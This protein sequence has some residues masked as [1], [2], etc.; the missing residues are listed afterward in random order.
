V[1][2]SPFYDLHFQRYAIYW[3]T[4]DE[5]G[6]E[7][8]REMLAAAEKQEREL[9]ART[10]DFVRLGE[11]QPEIDHD[12]LSERSSSNIGPEGRRWR[13]GQDGGWFSYRMKVPADGTKAAVQLE[14]WGHDNGPVFDL[15]VDGKVIASPQAA[16]KGSEGYYGVEYAIPD[17]LLKS[18][19]TITVRMQARQGEATGLI[20]G[21]R[22]VSTK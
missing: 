1:I 10:V 11:Q 12:M 13:A 7:K 21:L 20:Y 8:R 14:F 6:W 9:D 3:Q 5:S 18:G 4:S 17:A 22:I 19:E 2:L 15:L 16:A